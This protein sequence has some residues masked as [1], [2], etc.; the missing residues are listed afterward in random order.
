ASSLMSLGTTIPS[1]TGSP[2]CLSRPQLNAFPPTRS[3]SSAVN[4]SSV[5]HVSTNVIIL[6]S[7]S[8]CCF[9]EA[10]DSQ[11]DDGDGVE[12]QPGNWRREVAHGCAAQDDPAQDL[13]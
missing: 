6:A 4:S 8:H 12:R 3:R 9:L 11:A 1:G 5:L 7:P 13:N 10:D 2:A